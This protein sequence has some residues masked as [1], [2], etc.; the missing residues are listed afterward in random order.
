M[1]TILQFKNVLFT[2]VAVLT[3]ALAQNAKGNAGD[4]LVSGSNWMQGNGVNDYDNGGNVNNDW[5]AN[6]VG[7]VY[8]GEKWQCVELAQRL[9]ITRGWRGSAFPVSYAYE[10]YDQA[11]GMGMTAHPNGD[12]YVAVPG[13]MVIWAS[14]CG[15]LGIAGHVAVV[16]SVDAGHVYV[17]EQ[18][19]N[20][21]GRATCNRSGSNGSSLARS[22]GVGC[23][24]GVIHSPNN[25]YSNGG[26]VNPHINPVVGFN[27]DGRQELFAIGNTGQMY[28]MYQTSPNSGWSAWIS[29]GGTLAQNAIPAV[30]RNS[31]GRLELF[32]IGPG[33]T[34]YHMWETTAGSSTSWS[35]W[36][37]LGAS[38]LPATA[39][40]ATGTN[41]NGIM[42]VF[43][44]G[45]GNQLYHNYQTG[46]GNWSGWIGMGGNW[47]PNACIVAGNNLDGRQEVFLIGNT[48]NLYHINQTA[49]NGGWSGFG[50][51]GGSWS[52][53]ARP[54]LGRNAD[55]RL[56]V[57]IIGSSTHLHHIWQNSP[58]GSWSA[59]GD[60]G[61]SWQAGAKPI[62][63]NN[64]N[65]I[66]EIMLIGS[67]GNLYHN[68]AGGGGWSGWLSLGGSFTQDIRPTIGRNL[69]G[70][71]EV[72]ATGPNKDMLHL[73]QNTPNGSWSGWF[74]LGGSWN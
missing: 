22:D 61:G 16:D 21:N 71:I 7:S 28:H 5:G 20:A 14:N 59:W 6:Y 24:R 25:P 58:N 4:V 1:K 36:T 17:C 39:C 74:S 30:G 35:A 45:T 68:Y 15:G 47:N 8:C 33:G 44:I 32:V 53:T 62:T 48:G 69:D 54:A 23:I 72:F 52:Q 27:S 43:V 3:S 38:G 49:P 18:N 10:I 34:V 29:L 51:L 40:L 70:R 13:D 9:Y 55:G 50:N 66:I 64:Q 11:G 12:G 42:E 67:T 19:W 41:A 63:V 57:F 31:D 56:E 46:G 73:W 26:S 60:L 65:G 2:S 37:S